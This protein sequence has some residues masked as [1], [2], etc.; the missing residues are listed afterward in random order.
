MLLWTT[1]MQVLF[2]RRIVAAFSCCRCSSCRA[3]CCNV[4][5]SR[6]CCAESRSV[7]PIS[8][9]FSVK[10]VC[11]I[12]VAIFIRN[13]LPFLESTSVR[14]SPNSTW[15]VAS[16]LD[17]TRHVWRVESVHLAVWSLSNSTARHARLDT[18]W[19]DE[20][21]GIWAL[22]HIFKPIVNIREDFCVYRCFVVI[23]SDVDLGI[24]SA[25]TRT[26]IVAH[27]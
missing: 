18:S 3:A 9:R 15:L 26:A 7:F 17:T 21:S 8:W 12:R 1:W 2:C 10:N 16:R 27:G 19:R 14:L 20:P 25:T 22:T 4:K 24:V 6:V 13:T 23:F 11:F 5:Q